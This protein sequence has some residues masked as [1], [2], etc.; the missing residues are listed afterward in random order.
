MGQVE[1][2]LKVV[3][4]LVASFGDRSLSLILF[5]TRATPNSLA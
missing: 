1:Q 5:E 4:A 2:D 3:V